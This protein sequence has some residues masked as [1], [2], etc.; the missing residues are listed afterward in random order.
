MNESRRRPNGIVTAA[1]PSSTEST[2]PPASLLSQA[3]PP[4]NHGAS[5]PPIIVT[6]LSRT[7]AS[8]ATTHTL[9]SPQWQSGFVKHVVDKAGH[10]A[11]PRLNQWFLPPSQPRVAEFM[12]KVYPKISYRD[13]LKRPEPLRREAL[14][15]AAEEYYQATGWQLSTIVTALLTMLFYI[16]ASLV[17][18]ILSVVSPTKTSTNV[19]ITCKQ[20]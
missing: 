5:P 6:P 20:K 7:A 2:M 8:T 12:D 15:K 16:P 19:R 18:A 14:L 17:Y 11:Q 10:E 13:P 1:S 3:P 9:P 4:Q